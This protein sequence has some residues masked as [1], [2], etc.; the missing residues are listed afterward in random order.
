[1]SSPLLPRQVGTP[2]NDVGGSGKHLNGSGRLGAVITTAEIQER[3]PFAATMGIEIVS[4]AKDEVRSTMA[5]A[6]EKCTTFGI[7]HGGAIMAYADTVGAVLDLAQPGPQGALT[8]TIES[9]T[10]FLRAVQGGQV[11]GTSTLLHAGRTTIVVVTDLRDDAGKL[12]AQRHPD[13]GGYSA[14]GE[15]T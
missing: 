14:S 15:L 6:P 7:L 3:M 2:V 9:K 12:I 8:T 5:W 11:H 10:N 1:M 4:A 13:P